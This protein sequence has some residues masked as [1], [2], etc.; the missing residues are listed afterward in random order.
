MNV[1]QE[2]VLGALLVMDMAM[3]IGWIGYVWMV[4]T[5]KAKWNSVTATAAVVTIIG[6]C[7]WCFAK[8]MTG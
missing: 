5:G 4:T 3:G 6:L 1:P 2:L 7:V 8:L